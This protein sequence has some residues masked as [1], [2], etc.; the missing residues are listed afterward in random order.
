MGLEQNQFLRLCFNFSISNQKEVIIYLRKLTFTAA[1]YGA[2][3]V[4]DLCCST[5]LQH[6]EREKPLLHV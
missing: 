1:G 4:P 5:T 6:T 3:L 2:V